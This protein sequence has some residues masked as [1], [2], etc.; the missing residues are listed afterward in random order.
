M[1]WLSGWTYRKI[2]II[3]ES[4]VDADLTDFPVLVKLTSTNFDFS[5]ALSTGNDIRFTSSDGTTLLK[6]ER[7]RHD[8]ANSLAEYWVKIPS[9]SGSTNT[10]FYIYY[11][12]TSASDGAD[13][14]NVWDT[15]YKCVLNF[16][17][18]LSDSTSNNNSFTSLGDISYTNSIAALGLHKGTSTSSSGAYLGNTNLDFQ[19]LTVEGFFRKNDQFQAAIGRRISDG[20]GYVA[21]N[22]ST[23]A[24]AGFRFMIGAYNIVV[25]GGTPSNNTWYHIVGTYDHSYAR[26]YVNGE[27][28]NSISKT[29]D[30]VYSTPSTESSY[31]VRLLYANQFY[32]QNTYNCDADMVRVSNIARSAAWLK[33]SYNSGNNS[34]VSYGTQEPNNSAFLNFFN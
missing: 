34:L 20:N 23:D 2:I 27:L 22:L 15:N 5:R 4:K 17:S 25:S 19:N 33:A 3:D 7:E 24:T 29:D 8:S 16:K 28:I 31:I 12:N 10:S 1:A 26:L 13:T 6:Y 14:N 32:G 21:W 11:G 9:V 18:N 30:L